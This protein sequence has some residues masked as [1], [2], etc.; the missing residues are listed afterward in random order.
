MYQLATEQYGRHDLAMR[1]IVLGFGI[2]FMPYALRIA[3]RTP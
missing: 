2:T 3:L 1:S